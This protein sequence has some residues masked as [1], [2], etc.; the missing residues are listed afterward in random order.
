MTQPHSSFKCRDGLVFYKSRVVVPKNL[1]LRKKLLTEFHDSKQA[2][3]SGVL[4]T[5]KRLAQQ[6]YW[7]SL[8]KAVQ[9]FCTSMAKAMD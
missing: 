3:H 6:F 2:G 1:E 7:P 4:R 9:E 8:Y 5:F